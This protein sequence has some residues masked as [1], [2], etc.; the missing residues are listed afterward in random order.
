MKEQ[1]PYP[2]YQGV[3]TQGRLMGQSDIGVHDYNTD[4]SSDY[5]LLLTLPRGVKVRIC[6]YV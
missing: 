3:N 1:A 4:D 6:M 2:S 5:D